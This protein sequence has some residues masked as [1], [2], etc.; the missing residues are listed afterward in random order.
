MLRLNGLPH[1]SRYPEAT[2]KRMEEHVE[3]HFGGRGDEQVMNVP[4]KYLDGEDE[5]AAELRL[6]AQLQQIGYKVRR[7]E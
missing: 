7:G 3:I 2:V 1:I 5:E 6:L 4:L